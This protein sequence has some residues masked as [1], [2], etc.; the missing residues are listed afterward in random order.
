MDRKIPLT[1]IE[2]ALHLTGIKKI[3]IKSYTSTGR[4]KQL[5]VTSS[6]GTSA[7]NATDLRKALGWSRL[8]STNFTLSNDVDSTLFE[9]KGYGHGVGLCQWSALKMARDGK[10]YKEILSFFYPGTI[11]QLN[12]SL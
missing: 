11:I 6:S 9:G 8:P 10:T 5:A 7:I 2:K 3:S 4:V 12:E 1:E